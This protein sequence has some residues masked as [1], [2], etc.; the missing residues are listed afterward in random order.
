MAEDIFGLASIIP[1]AERAL[2]EAAQA[3]VPVRTG[4]TRDS[5]NAHTSATADGARVELWG[6][7][8]A[9][10]VITGTRAHPIDAV[11]APVLAF[12]WERMG[13]MFFGPH[14]NHPGTQP[15]DFRRA[16]ARD[17]APYLQRWGQQG[18]SLAMQNL[19]RKA[20]QAVA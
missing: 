11:N 8:V 1:L 3:H 17:L 4:Q 20:V 19:K 13:A 2:V 6:S 12:Y 15:N 16:V 14:V 10:W 5:L 9:Q 18:A 7:Q